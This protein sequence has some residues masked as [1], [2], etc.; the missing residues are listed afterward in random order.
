[1]GQKVFDDNTIIID[2]SPHKCRKSSTSKEK[3]INIKV[4]KILLNFFKFY[5][6]DIMAYAPHRIEY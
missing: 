4:D 5:N 3:T 6:E 1:M 2:L